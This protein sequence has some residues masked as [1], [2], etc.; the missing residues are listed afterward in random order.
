[1]LGCI[2]ASLILGLSGWSVFSA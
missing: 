2:T 1:V